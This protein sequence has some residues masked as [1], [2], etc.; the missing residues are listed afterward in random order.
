[1]LVGANGAGKTTLLQI[2]AGKYM[3]GQEMVRVL[4]RP[5]FHDM[6]RAK[7]NGPQAEQGRCCSASFIIAFDASWLVCRHLHALAS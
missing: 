2:L 5:P 3:V 7:I 1:L 4:G 6:V